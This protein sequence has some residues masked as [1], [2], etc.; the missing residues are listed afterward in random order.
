MK[1]KQILLCS[2]LA[3]PAVGLQSCLSDQED[4]FSENSSARIS[5]YLDKTQSVLLDS[6][7]GWVFDVYPG[8]RLQYGGFA[9]TLKF[10]ESQVTVGSELDLSAPETSLYKLA[11]D[12]GPVLSFDSY[13]TLM[14]FFAT[15]SSQMVNSFE[16]D[17]EFV[18]DSVGTDRIKMHGK[19]NQNVV[20]LH[21]LH[22]P[23][24][25]YLNAADAMSKAFKMKSATGMVNDK[26]VVVSFDGRIAT[27]DG[28]NGT[29]IE[30]PFT[31]T[32]EGLRFYEPINMGGKMVWAMKFD[33]KEQTLTASDSDVVL[34]QVVNKVVAGDAAFTRTIYYAGMQSATVNGD[35]TSWL[36][37]TANGNSIQI[38]AT[39]N[40]T[41]N[42]RTGI[43]T[44]TKTDGTKAQL[45]V[46]QVEFDKDIV[47]NYTLKYTAA[48]AMPT[49]RNA[50]IAK[51]ANG[52]P[53]ITVEFDYLSTPMS[54]VFDA[55]WDDSE[56][57]LTIKSGD[58][59]GSLSFFGTNLFAYTIFGGMT[60]SGTPMTTELKPDVEAA[61]TFSATSDAAGKVVV[62]APFSGMYQGTALTQIYL[63]AFRQQSFATTPM[64]R[65]DVL[66]NPV[67]QKK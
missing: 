66:L 56:A 31:M 2:L 60:S 35:A 32:D 30:R 19:R 41:G 27:I 21:K 64:G 18:I 1:I 15:P 50:V 43:I 3:L 57:T 40:N 5:N 14:H 28:G 22:R 7:H 59:L 25:D 9:Y 10:T 8:Y 20:Y 45:P 47:G 16:G 11:K 63:G 51:D 17:F 49:T 36:K 38:E 55:T 46:T 61:F 58:Y 37:A 33:A 65:L 52:N 53:T 44:I 24:A 54:L 34:H 23:S 48:N 4:L 13:N 12:N 29:T 62:S 42:V 26:T 6:E 67:L 39:A